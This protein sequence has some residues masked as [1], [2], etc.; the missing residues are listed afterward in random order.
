MFKQHIAEQKP[1]SRPT[2][3]E[4]C[5]ES[6]C[7]SSVRNRYFV[8]KRLTPDAL[9]VEQRY[10]IE[11][12]RLM[13]RAVVGWGVVF[14]YP[15]KPTM[16]AKHDVKGPT[17][18]LSIGAGLALDAAGRE[19]F[20][21]DTVDLQFDDM[22]LLDERGRRTAPH[23]E[24]LKGCWLLKVHYAERDMGPTA[25]TDSC[26]CE[27]QEWDQVC[28]TVR[29]S[30][31]PID[32]EDCCEPPK[33]DLHCA[34][35]AGP[36]CRE[37]GEPHDG[38]HEAH[39][40]AHEPHLEHP[41]ERER[42]N[43]RLEH[44]H[45]DDPVRRGGCQC[46]CHYLSELDCNPDCEKLCVIEEPCAR[47]RVDLD[48]GVPLACV[49]LEVDECGC[50]SFCEEIEACGPRR[51]VKRNDVL[52][53]LIR[54]CD[55]TR[56]SKI[57]WAPWHRARRPVPWLD[58]AKSFGDTGPEGCYVT[59]DYWVEFS[60]PVRADT[61]R[62]D[63]FSMTILVPEDEGGWLTPMRVPILGVETNEGD[64]DI[65]AGHV[66]RATMMV[67]SDWVDDA[68]RARHT[69]FADDATSVEIEVLGDYMVDCNG[70]T[71]DANAAGLIAAPTGKGVPGDRLISK[72]AV[73]ARPPHL[74]DGKSHNQG[75]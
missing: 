31:S 65:P 8:G 70:Q 10:L 5:T 12:R 53:D 52:F 24:S 41:G 44:E 63:C 28:E 18:R 46:L 11:R 23:R 26:S 51:L 1:R 62:A 21:T 55:L 30:L 34:C 29:Y 72:F 69:V 22:L 39:E 57:G 9:K 58:F 71:V 38:R 73:E 61:V 45:T 74:F 6:E 14:G 16:P 49:K 3:A 13:N 4:C 2:R 59:A 43:G 19:L 25:V 32:C 60:R 68:L 37:A 20:Q 35:G 27:H 50:W 54:G 40:T 64:P 66:T 33:C 17:G 48:H 47:I 75:V 15:I 7:E 67:D 36:C 42:Q 56:I